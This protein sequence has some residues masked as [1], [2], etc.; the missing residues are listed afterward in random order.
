MDIYNNLPPELQSIIQK[1]YERILLHERLKEAQRYLSY[2]LLPRHKCIHT[3][4]CLYFQTA[5]TQFSVFSTVSVIDH[6]DPGYNLNKVTVHID[7][8]SPEKNSIVSTQLFNLRGYVEYFTSERSNEYTKN[9]RMVGETVDGYLNFHSGEIDFCI[10]QY[11]K[12]LDVRE[13]PW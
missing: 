8:D 13:K 5:R 3:F 12:M 11:H 6:D 7:K 9:A 10:N 4:S 2:F 1:K